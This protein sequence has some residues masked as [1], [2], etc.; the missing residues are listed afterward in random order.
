MVHRAKH[1]AQRL[2]Q[3]AGP[4]AKVLVTTFTKNLAQVIDAQ[5]VELAGSGVRLYAEVLNVDALEFRA[6]AIVGTGQKEL[7]PSAIRQLDGEEREVA[8]RR[9][10]NLVYVSSSRA[11][12]RLYVS[13]V[14]ARS[15]LINQT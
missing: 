7:P 1:L 11:R 4:D 10:Q 3:Y 15:E 5:L 8:W 2:G 12:E 6:V 14:G 13:W 9:E